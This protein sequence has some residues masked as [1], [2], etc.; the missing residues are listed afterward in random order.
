MSKF[1]VDEAKSK[2]CPLTQLACK[3][4]DCMKWRFEV[5]TEYQTLDEGQK[6]EG[7]GWEE[8]TIF[9][10]GDDKSIWS[11]DIKIGRAHV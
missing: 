9:H 2:F 8:V 3:A 11:K 10:K 6:P 4:N 5:E 1:S 7:D